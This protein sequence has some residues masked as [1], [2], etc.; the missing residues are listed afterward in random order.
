MRITL[1][2]SWAELCYLASDWDRLL[3]DSSSDTIFLTWE[4]CEAWWKTYGD[5]RSLFVLTAWE[6]AELMGVAPFYVDRRRHW[7]KLWTCL[8][9]IG[10]GSGDSDYLD[11][12]TKRGWEH[13]VVAVFMQFLE[14]LPDEWDWIQI[15]GARQDS[16]CLA[17]LIA[18]ATERGWNF[19]SEII[20]C[21]TLP[22]PAS[23]DS[24]LS[25]LRPRIRTK[26][27][28]TLA[29][30]ED[31]LKLRPTECAKAGELDTWLGQLFEVHTRR[32]EK[33]HQPGVFR[34]R[35]KQSFYREVSLSTLEKGWLAF[36]RL[37]WGERPLALQYGFR[38][39][40]RLYVLQE[41]Y[42]PSFEVLR[43]GIALRSWV[44]RGGIEQG[45]AEYDF[46][47]GAV[48][49]KLDWGAR[50]RLSRLVQLARK[51]AATWASISFPWFAR[52]VRESAGRLLPESVR[53]W[54]Q[55]LMVWR[56][57][58]QWSIPRSPQ[59]PLVKRLAHWSA[60]QIYCGTPLGAMSRQLANRYTGRFSRSSSASLR[61]RSAPVSTIFR[62]HR[63]NDD[64][65]PF[66]T[67][68]PVARFSAQ[69]EYLAR[70][71]QVVSL[72]QL[73]SGLPQ[74]AGD[75]SCV[76]VTFDDGYRD[77]FIHAFPVLKKI[78]IPATIFLTTGYIE[79]GRLP[80]YDQVRL[81]FKL[82]LRRRLSL[83]AVGGPDAPLGNEDQ[84]LEAMARTLSWL[85]VI[86]EQ[87]RLVGLPYMFNELG[88]PSL[89]N[90]PATML[91]WDQIRQMKKDG[92][93][94]G[95]HTVTHPALGGLPSSRLKEEILGSKRTIENRLQTPV[96]HFAYP[97]GKQSD[98]GWQAKQ[99]IQ[100]AGFQ[101][102]VTTIPGVNGPG[103]DLLELRR[104]SLDEPDL[105]M[106]GIKLDW[107]KMSA[108][109]AG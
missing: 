99:V 41:G 9:I 59:K 17:A 100:A 109:M 86:D 74:T 67:A 11:C 80:W 79:S 71:F 75:K 15:Q 18:N 12:F 95:A 81:A 54:R 42:D 34:S 50:P 30:L 32:W 106:F 70:H 26:V 104:M 78:G 48:R 53:S 22:L 94:F 55:E 73:A 58:R 23:W 40:N 98:F 25:T 56:R 85:R 60:S 38:Y 20:P 8:R 27:R 49:H 19:S 88:V 52:S 65:D 2:R 10:D 64:H 101:T 66:L 108:T 63:V 14:S 84:R 33:S 51:P 97:F 44:V 7:H 89:L 82:T 69:M 87:E 35:A 107:S 68:L 62:Y 102:A 83:R 37:S 57:E 45:L 31:Q 103:Q 39:H 91:G 6:G 92:I 96:R 5:D 77:N 93:S 16:P 13:Q 21:V 29:H 105:G 72:D 43:P 28:S 36:H 90:L 61:L 3:A 24:Y 4:W 1:H 46:L 47:A 76:A